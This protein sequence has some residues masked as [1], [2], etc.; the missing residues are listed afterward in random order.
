MVNILVHYFLYGL[1]ILHC[2]RG[3]RYML[4]YVTIYTSINIPVE[5]AVIVRS[6]SSIS[7]LNRS[8]LVSRDMPLSA[9]CLVHLQP[10][11]RVYPCRVSETG[12]HYPSHCAL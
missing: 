10:V 8:L 2:L 1:E 4:E 12:H 9:R 7:S 3:L 6:G 5:K 11:F